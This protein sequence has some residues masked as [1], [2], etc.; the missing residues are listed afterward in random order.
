MH[1]LWLASKKLDSRLKPEA[2]GRIDRIGKGAQHKEHSSFVLMGI[3]MLD[4]VVWWWLGS[5]QEGIELE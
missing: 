2:Q 5:N 4:F 1:L 3:V